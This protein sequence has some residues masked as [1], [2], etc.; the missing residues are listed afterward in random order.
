MKSVSRR[1]FVKNAGLGIGT[2]AMS[3]AF[4]SL[5]EMFSSMN[6]RY[7]GEKLNVALCGL[8]RYANILA[9]GLQASEFCQLTGIITGSPEKEVSWKE[10]YGIPSKNIYNYE[11]FDEIRDNKDIDL[12]YVVLPNGMH[13]EFTIRAA[14]ASKHVIVEK[15]MANTAEECREMIAACKDAG[16]QLAL[17]YR[18]H[19]EPNH[20][21]IM[22]LGQEKVFGQVRLIEA[23]LGFNMTGIDPGDWHLNKKLSGGG[24]LMNLGVYCIQ[25]NRYVLGEEPVSVTAQ[26]LPKI[27]PDLFVEVEEGITWQLNFP[28]GAVGTSTT[29]STSSVD[30]FY[31]AADHGFF[32]MSPAISYGP[33][34]G[35]S[36]SGPFDFPVINQQAAQLDGIGK[37]I[38]ENKKLPIHI[39]GEEGLKDMIVIEAI[40]K[41]AETGRK[42]VIK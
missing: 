25:S 12:V 22:R 42:I 13:K 27:R 18:L 9:K 40:Y 16:V 19:Y 6:G 17:G 4:F 28:N 24:P 41:A 21:E 33:F 10:K 7:Q 26:F 1:S 11:N 29:T 37:Y 2:V 20:L 31:A 23:S 36:S 14:T 39:A 5:E 3:P 30:R 32:E 8:G 38:L 35:R 15:P 34:I